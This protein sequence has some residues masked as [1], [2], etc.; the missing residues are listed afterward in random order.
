MLS[1]LVHLLFVAATLIS[2]PFQVKSQI[3]Y[4]D[5]I[6]VSLPSIDQVL[7]AEPVPEEPIH[8]PQ[9]MADEPPEIAI[10]DPTTRPAAVIDKP[11]P[12]PERKPRKDV[13]LDALKS[14]KDQTGAREGEID[15]EAT[16]AGSPFAGATVDNASF[17]YPFW[18]SLAFDKIGR[19]YRSTVPY[20]GTLVCV[21]HFQVMKSGRVIELE[22]I[23]S[24]GIKAFDNVCLRAIERSSPFPPLPRQFREEI[25]GITLP[26]KWTPR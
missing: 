11:E 1:M 5:V 25:I 14:D 22:V 8:I 3:D 17:D 6:R 7:P 4:G 15:I 16:G 9:A 13:N 21:M 20:D 23:Q 12:K 18:Y 24:S 2:S 19:N 26:I 10:T